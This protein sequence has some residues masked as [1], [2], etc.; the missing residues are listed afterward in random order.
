MIPAA[1]SFV[2]DCGST[3]SNSNSLNIVAGG[4]SQSNCINPLYNDDDIFT[5]CLPAFTNSALT[6]YPKPS[7]QPVAV[8]SGLGI[9]TDLTRDLPDVSLFASDGLM[10]A[11]FYIVCEQDLDVN[12]AP[13]SLN[14][15]QPFYT[16][17]PVG[18]TSSSA[19]TFAGIMALVNQKMASLSA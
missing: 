2:N 7:W 8:A 3:N 10:S 18:G 14:T 13:C 15:T 6:G 19:P 1:Q 5:G 12:D 4:G 17:V 16:F 11:S 9:T